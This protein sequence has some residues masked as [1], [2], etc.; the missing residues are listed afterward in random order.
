VPDFVA[1]A[2]RPTVAAL[3]IPMKNDVLA[4][5][6]SYYVAKRRSRS[7]LTQHIDDVLGAIIDGDLVVNVVG[8]VVY[9][10]DFEFRDFCQ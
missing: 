6:V 10:R 4:T 7:N 8:K 5:S 9:G 3:Y 1:N 2:P